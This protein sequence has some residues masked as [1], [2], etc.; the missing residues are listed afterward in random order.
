MLEACRG[1]PSPYPIGTSA[2]RMG[3]ST[4]NVWP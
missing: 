1:M 2:T 4:T 3:S